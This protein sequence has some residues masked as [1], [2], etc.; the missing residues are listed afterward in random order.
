MSTQ[1]SKPKKA[2]KSETPN[3]KNAKGS[4]IPDRPVNQTKPPRTGMESV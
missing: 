2:P 3:P 4:R 1:P